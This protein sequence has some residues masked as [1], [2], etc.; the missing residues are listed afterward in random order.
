MSCSP[1]FVVNSLSL[2]SNSALLWVTLLPLHTFLTPSFPFCLLS[3]NH[4]FLTL[5]SFFVDFFLFFLSF[6]SLSDSDPVSTPITSSSDSLSLNS[7][8]LPFFSFLDVCPHPPLADTFL[9]K[10]AC[11]YYLFY[12]W[13]LVTFEVRVLGL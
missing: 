9:H 7:P 2:R 1:T 5:I 8:L 12:F 13:D 11:F 6:F 3:S 4:I 10:T